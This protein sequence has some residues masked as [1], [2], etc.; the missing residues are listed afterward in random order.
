MRLSL[1]PKATSRSGWPMRTSRELKK[2]ITAHEHHPERRTPAG[3]GIATGHAQAFLVLQTGCQAVRRTCCQR[4]RP[5]PAASQTRAITRTANPGC[6][7]DSNERISS[8]HTSP[9]EI[10]RRRSLKT[11]QNFAAGLSC[12]GSSRI[13]SSFLAQY[14]RSR[15]APLTSLT[16]PCFSNCPM[17]RITVL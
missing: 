8:G 12:A 2:T 9:L 10:T 16:M 13:S 5:R 15:F 6:S 17:A 1:V 7:A 14:T 4:F 3:D 11:N